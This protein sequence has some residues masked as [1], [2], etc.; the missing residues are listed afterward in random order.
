MN[1]GATPKAFSLH[2]PAFAPALFCPAPLSGHTIAPL[3]STFHH[4]RFNRQKGASRTHGI[5]ADR[6]KHPPPGPVTTIWRAKCKS[7]DLGML[8]V[9]RSRRSSPVARASVRNE[10]SRVNGAEDGARGQCAES[11]G[12]WGEDKWEGGDI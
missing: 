8:L 7:S 10:R 3:P 1:E 11:S 4:P 12:A 2:Y 6:P 9:G 5:E